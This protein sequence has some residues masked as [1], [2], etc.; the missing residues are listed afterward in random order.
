MSKALHK[1]VASVQNRILLGSTITAGRLPNLVGCP[2]VPRH[3]PKFLDH[4]SSEVTGEAYA[5]GTTLLMFEVSTG[6]RRKGATA[7][8]SDRLADLTDALETMA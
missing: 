4:S 8:V 1:A 5:E 7:V 2:M 6:G 3:G